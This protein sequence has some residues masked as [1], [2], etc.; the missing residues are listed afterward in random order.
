M[1]PEEILEQLKETNRRLHEIKAEIEG[2]IEKNSAAISRLESMQS[3]SP[4]Q[5]EAAAEPV[6]PDKQRE[7]AQ[8]Y[9][10]LQQLWN[11]RE[12]DLLIVWKLSWTPDFCAAV[13]MTEEGDL[14]GT[15]YKLNKQGEPYVRRR[16]V[17]LNKNKPEYCSLSE[18][19]EPFRKK[20]I[21]L[22]H[23]TQEKEQPE[24]SE[25]T[26]GTKILVGCT[27]L[28]LDRD[29]GEKTRVGILPSYDEIRYKTMGY[30]T[31]NYTEVTRVSDADGVETV[32]DESPL[33]KALLDK[34]E[35]NTFRFEQDGSCH[36]YEILSVTE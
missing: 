22:Y 2:M 6:R 9:K 19:D 29:T 5:K 1:M 25:D 12:K 18:I 20:V 35:G 15:F 34:R 8:V 26:G 17:K 36:T 14:L 10:T 33:G 7:N 28:L 24:Q 16:G 23:A 3:E 31:K 32:S 27:V 4:L 21:R 30:R 11:E 13:Q